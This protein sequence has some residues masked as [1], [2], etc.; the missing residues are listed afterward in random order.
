MCL[1]QQIRGMRSQEFH[2][3]FGVGREL[4]HCPT[5]QEIKERWNLHMQRS[6]GLEL[7]NPDEVIQI[8]GNFS[9]RW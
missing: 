8:W 5:L 6:R 3:G 7:C 2:G 1:W 9:L 4:R